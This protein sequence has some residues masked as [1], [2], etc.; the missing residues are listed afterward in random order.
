MLKAVVNWLFWWGN[1]VERKQYFSFA[2]W[3]EMLLAQICEK[4]KNYLLICFY[5][6][7]TE[8]QSGFAHLF[9]SFVD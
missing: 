7:S 2:V 6:V 8:L 9:N 3:F 5:S 4:C 1:K